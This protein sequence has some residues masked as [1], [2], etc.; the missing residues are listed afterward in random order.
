[1][2]VWYCLW[3]YDIVC[4]CVILFVTVWYR[5]WLYDIVCDCLILFVTG[6]YC[7]GLYDIVCDCVIVFVTV[8]YCLWLCD[9]VCDYMVLF[10][11]VWYCLWMSDIVCDWVILFVTGGGRST[12]HD[13]LRHIWTGY[14]QFRRHL[15]HTSLWVSLTD[16]ETGDDLAPTN[17]LRWLIGYSSHVIRSPLSTTSSQILNRQTFKALPCRWIH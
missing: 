13:R 4:D 10:L 9:I 16:D 7:L 5:L 1:V 11:T 15:R 3:L 14:A 12:P 17:Q 8:W 6:W 2:T